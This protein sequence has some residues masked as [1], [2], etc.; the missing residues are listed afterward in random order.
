MVDSYRKR[1][2]I[3]SIDPSIISQIDNYSDRIASSSARKLG[4]ASGIGVGA[5]AW[6]LGFEH[7]YLFGLWGA[8]AG[9]FFAYTTG[10]DK[11]REKAIVANSNGN[12]PLKFIG[13]VP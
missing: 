9:V 13:S 2:L 7:Q 1:V 11:T 12:D 5:L 10:K 8:A 6:Y 3:A 4:L